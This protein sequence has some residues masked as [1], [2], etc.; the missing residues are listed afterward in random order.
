MVQLEQKA[1]IHES[2]G[3]DGRSGLGPSDAT[4]RSSGK[5]SQRPASRPHHGSPP[6][7]WTYRAGDRC[8]HGPILNCRLAGESPVAVASL[9]PRPAAPAHCTTCLGSLCQGSFAFGLGGQPA[10]APPPGPAGGFGPS[11]HS[12]GGST[13]PPLPAPTTSTPATPLTPIATPHTAPRPSL[14]RRRLSEA[15]LPERSLI[16]TP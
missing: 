13:Q 7:S 5:N 10:I 9:H 14:A 1:P 15:S 12:A 16:Q 11:C 8:I 4:S 2:F 3:R 6:Q